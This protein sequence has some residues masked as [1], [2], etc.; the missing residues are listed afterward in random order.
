MYSS[1]GIV[2]QMLNERDQDAGIEVCVCCERTYRVEI[3]FCHYIIL[4]PDPR[5]LVQRYSPTFIFVFSGCVC[6]CVCVCV[7]IG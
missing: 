5:P 3:G 2:E 6:V 4:S 7:V 1:L